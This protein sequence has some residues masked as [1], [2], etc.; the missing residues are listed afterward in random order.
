MRRDGPIDSGAVNL[1]AVDLDLETRRRF[2]PPN[3][4]FH[5]ICTLTWKS[6]AMSARDATPAMAGWMRPRT[7]CGTV[8][9]NYMD[10][11][12]A[13][14]PVVPVAY[15][16]ILRRPW[17]LSVVSGMSWKQMD[18]ESLRHECKRRFRGEHTGCCSTCGTVI[19][20][21]MACHFASFH[22]DLAQSWQCP[23]SWCTTWKGTLQDCVDH[24]QQKH[25]VPNSV[26]EANL[27]RWF[28]PPERYGARPWSRISP[29]CRLMFC[30]LVSGSSLVHHYL[31]FGRNAVHAS[32][33]GKFM[34]GASS[35]KHI[36]KDMALNY[37]NCVHVPLN[38]NLNL[39]HRTRRGRS[40]I[41]VQSVTEPAKSG[42]RRHQI[43]FVAIRLRDSDG[44]SPSCK[45]RR[46]VSP[47]AP[48]VS[49]D[50]QPSTSA[51]SVKSSAGPAAYYV[52]AAPR[53]HSLMY[54]GR[55][56]LVPVS[57]ELP[58][59]PTG[60]SYSPIYSPSWSL[61]SLI[62]HL[63]SHAHPR[64]VLV[65]VWWT[66]VMTSRLWWKWVGYSLWTLLN[67]RWPVIRKLWWN[68]LRTIK[69]QLCP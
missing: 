5:G 3:G 64:F 41:G 56:S 33:R 60:T 46:A 15:L 1:D 25:S 21:Y 2:G 28:P 44:D 58:R 27:A 62:R 22:L 48:E 30:Y 40:Q 52:S 34:A 17:P 8:I 42:F 43:F 32:L 7:S 18:Y 24:I 12:D 9:K 69:R 13:D 36:N 51:S 19:K 29:V 53:P 55:P 31:V 57:L 67:H 50:N 66:P 39:I 37:H 4:A 65:S 35:N 54:D 61:H 63:R 38:P 26:K 68:R 20:N 6:P 10:M 47:V 49:A 23:V 45:T 14:A 59:S 16:T 11:L